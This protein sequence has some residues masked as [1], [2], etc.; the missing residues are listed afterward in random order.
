M[1]RTSAPPRDLGSTYSLPTILSNIRAWPLMSPYST[2]YCRAVDL[3]VILVGRSEP[4]TG[5]GSNSLIHFVPSQEGLDRGRRH[6]SEGIDLSFSGGSVQRFEGLENNWVLDLG[7]FCDALSGLCLGRCW[8]WR[9]LGSVMSFFRIN[10]YEDTS[11]DLR[12]RLHPR[13]ETLLWMVFL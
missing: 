2:L 12:I 8:P 3:T 4:L 7:L 5:Q 10:G 1:A 11:D 9:K 13:R 6:K